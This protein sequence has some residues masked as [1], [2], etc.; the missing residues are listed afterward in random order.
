MWARIKQTRRSPWGDSC[1]R[2]RF[3]SFLPGTGPSCGIPPAAPARSAGVPAVAS[4]QSVTPPAAAGLKLLLLGV[5]GSV[6]S[7]QLA[8]KSARQKLEG[9]GQSH[10]R[11]RSVNCTSFTSRRRGRE[12]QPVAADTLPPLRLARGATFPLGEGTETWAGA[13][14]KQAAVPTSS[15]AARR[16]GRARHSTG[17]VAGEPRRPRRQTPRFPLTLAPRPPLAGQRGTDGCSPCCA[18]GSPR[19]PGADVHRAKPPSQPPRAHRRRPTP[20]A[21]H[22]CGSGV[23]GSRPH[24]QWWDPRRGVSVGWGGLAASPPRCKLGA[25]ERCDSERC[26]EQEG[27]RKSSHTKQV[28]GEP[29]LCCFLLIMKYSWV[30]A[31]FTTFL[32]Y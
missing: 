25:R 15:V 26:E 14:A 6:A 11:R 3:P 2:R 23:P 32:S 28:S 1:S 17:S 24:G 7:S 5:L 12:L 18:L 31:F 16:G 19:S 8:S 10:R 4:R 13:A 30:K 21:P 20:R 9:S 29:K 27:R 22:R